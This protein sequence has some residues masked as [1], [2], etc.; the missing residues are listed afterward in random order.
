MG[1]LAAAA[2]FIAPAATIAGGILGYKGVEDTNVANR[3]IASARNVM[4]VEEAKKARDFS[5]EQA[6]INRKYME[7]MSSTAVQ[8]RMADMRKGGINPILAG[9]FDASSPA[10]A[11]APTAKANAHGYTAQ[12]KMQGLLDNMGSALSLKKMVSEIAN[13]NANTDLTTRKTNLT[14]PINRMMDILDK[15]IQGASG[16]LNDYK[17]NAAEIRNELLELKKYITGEKAAEA[18]EIRNQPGVQLTPDTQKRS[19]EFK[20]KTYQDYYRRKPLKGEL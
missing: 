8:R 11:A 5:A 14:D 19:K 7:R 15:V 17:R 13:L 2:P 10:G 12:N 16:N 9:K 18:A 1:I 3:D 20:K 6:E 4:E